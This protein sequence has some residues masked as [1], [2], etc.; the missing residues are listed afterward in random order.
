[1]GVLPWHHEEL[2]KDGKVPADVGLLNTQTVISGV[3]LHFKNVSKVL[4]LLCTLE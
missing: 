1:M 3:I 4:N 2:Y